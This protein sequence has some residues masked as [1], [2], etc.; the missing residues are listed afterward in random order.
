[1]TSLPS[2]SK[3]ENIQHDICISFVRISYDSHVT[4]KNL[5]RKIFIFAS[6]IA[7]MTKS[8]PIIL[9][10]QIVLF[11]LQIVTFAPISFEHLT[12]FTR[13]KI[14]NEVKIHPSFSNKVQWMLYCK[15]LAAVFLHGL[16][17]QPSLSRS[18]G[19]VQKRPA[20]KNY[21]H[22]LKA[23]VVD[24]VRSMLPQRGK[25]LHIAFYT[26]I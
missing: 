20:L 5:Y 7:C 3:G 24:D 18:Y 1:M 19:V 2:K 23:A 13:S 25:K 9:L 11:F 6:F 14:I 22:F 16:I 8:L 10:P 17:K 12:I 21:S 4:L 26:A 15:T